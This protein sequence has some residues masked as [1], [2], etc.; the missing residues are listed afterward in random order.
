MSRR[1]KPYNPELLTS[2]AR[3]I[4]TVAKMHGQSVVERDSE[5]ATGDGIWNRIISGRRAA[6]GPTLKMAKANPPRC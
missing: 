2:R 3:K 6:A 4:G 1:H 5:F